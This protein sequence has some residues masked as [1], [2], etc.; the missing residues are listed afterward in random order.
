MSYATFFF[1]SIAIAIFIYAAFR[2][3]LVWKISNATVLAA[4]AAYIPV[5]T[6]GLFAGPVLA[7]KV[8]PTSAVTA[9]LML[10]TIGFVLWLMKLLGAGD[11]KLMF[12]VGLFIGWDYL[13]PYA[14]GLIV[15]AVIALFIM[16]VSLPAAFA[17]SMVGMRID[18][19]RRSGKMP[20]GVVMVTA[21]LATLSAKYFA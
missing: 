5:A 15:S 8:D 10:F 17:N 4:T 2:D 14:L 7:A 6:T 20:Y 12:P 13:L 3:F 18:E 1:L 16:N 11:A 19:I 21:L 9:A